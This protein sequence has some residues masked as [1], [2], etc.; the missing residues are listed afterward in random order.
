MREADVYY[1]KNGNKGAVKYLIAVA[2]PDDGEILAAGQITDSANGR[3]VLSMIVLTDGAGSARSGAYAS[4][5]DEDMKAARA[6]EQKA[7]AEEGR[8]RSLYMLRVPSG[9]LKSGSETAVRAV[10]GII[11]AQ[12][13]EIVIT[14]NPFD[15]HPTHLA[16]G[17][18]VLAAIG[19]LPIEERPKTV[20]GGEVWRSL[21]WLPARYRIALPADTSDGAADRVLACH[22]SQIE[23]GKRYDAAAKGR[24]LQNATFCE[25]HS[26]DA[27]SEVAYFVD[28][29]RVSRGEISLSEFVEEVLF[30]FNEEIESGIM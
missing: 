29:S 7:A 22:K 10:A 25:S 20:W 24:R 21:D 19:S 30:V 11:A 13:P 14:H 16:A 23:G 28:L 17:K 12:K 2:H 9:E 8:F 4:Y 6:E 3:A 26:A 15:R 5:T 1:P 18:T 27:A